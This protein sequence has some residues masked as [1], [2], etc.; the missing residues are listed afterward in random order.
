MSERRAHPRMPIQCT[1][2]CRRLG[3]PGFDEFVEAIDLSPGG[4]R[5]R[6]A[7]ELKE[8]DLV[9]TTLNMTGEDLGLKG[10]VVRA[11][12]ALHL[13]HIAFLNLSERSREQL[14]AVLSLRDTPEPERPRAGTGSSRPNPFR[15]S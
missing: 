1:V 10:R 6:C 12:T 5:L 4:I 13:A 2:H 11:S 7:G 15:H 9:L 8:G 3:R 14:D